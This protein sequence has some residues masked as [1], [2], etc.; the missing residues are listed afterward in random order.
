MTAARIQQA[1][2]RTVTRPS[3]NAQAQQLSLRMVSANF[4]YARVQQTRV[5]VVSTNMPDDIISSARPQVFVCT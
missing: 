5:R 1:T 4:L 2:V 3:P